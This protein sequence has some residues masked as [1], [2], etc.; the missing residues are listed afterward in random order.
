MAFQLVISPEKL[1]QNSS[2]VGGFKHDLYF[3][4]YIWDVILPIDFHSIIFQDGEIAPPTSSNCWQL[5]PSGFQVAGSATQRLDSAHFH[6]AAGG[7]AIMGRRYY[8]GSHETWLAG[9]SLVKWSFRGK[10]IKV[11]SGKLT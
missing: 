2:L 10:I 4:K 6:S 11:P 8:W 7:G 1:P 9:K 5:L 3:P